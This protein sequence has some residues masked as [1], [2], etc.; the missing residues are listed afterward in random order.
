[1]A[2]TLPNLPLSQQ[3]D[4]NGVPLAGCLL[5]FFAVGTVATPQ[6]AYSDFG[7]T[8]PLPNPVVADQTGRLPMFYLADGQVHVRL[9]D[10]NGVQ[11][12]DYPTM[13]VIGPSSGG[14]GGGGSVNPNSI[15]STGDIKFRLTTETLTGWVKLN[16]QTIGSATSGATQRANADTQ[17]LFIYLW[18][19]FTNVK[20]PV[21]GGRGS[22]GLADF[23]ANK[24][25]GLPD[26]RSAI[27][28]GLDD[29]GNTAKG[30]LSSA[31]FPGSSDGPTTP[32][33]YG[34]EAN[35]ILL[36]AE[37]PKGQHALNFIDPG[38]SHTDPTENTSGL[39]G[40]SSGTCVLPG[41]QPVSTNTTGI[42]C[43]LIDNAGGGAHNNCQNFMLGTF[44]MSL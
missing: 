5:Y 27:F 31:N 1:M 4:I 19:N 28:C 7:L 24:T 13:Q 30:V 3:F 44:Y 16:N 9:T 33:G 41:S 11:I 2:G 34:G 8:L 43:T 26:A 40:G 14:G 15:F 18:N 21:S 35:H 23:N 25:I 10:A 42:T 32:C 12:F 38:H 37:A 22:S 6:N 36:V 17:N 39:R 29:M 20:C